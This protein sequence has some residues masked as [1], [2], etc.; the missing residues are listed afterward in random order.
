M[1]AIIGQAAEK[2]LEL[3]VSFDAA[4]PQRLSGDAFRIGLVMDN[5]LRNAVEFTERGRIDVA[6]DGGSTF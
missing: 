2:G 6:P 1:K 4:V 3:D 5:L